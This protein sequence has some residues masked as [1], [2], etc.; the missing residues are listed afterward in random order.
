M[1]PE[2]EKKIREEFIEFLSDKT[3]KQLVSITEFLNY[4]G[5]LNIEVTGLS[6]ELATQIVEEVIGAE[7]F[8]RIVSDER[9]TVY[10][11]SMTLDD[12]RYLEF[13]MQILNFECFWRLRKLTKDA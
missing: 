9:D 11:K 3:D 5:F 7:R 13:L 2:Q 10:F 6:K 8:I 12:L 1:S 4:K